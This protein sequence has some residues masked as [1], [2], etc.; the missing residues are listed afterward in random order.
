MNRPNARIIESNIPAAEAITQHTF[1]RRSLT[2]AQMRE[3]EDVTAWMA[4]QE[5]A[6]LVFIQQELAA[7]QHRAARRSMDW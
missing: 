5:E 2:P 6:E 3:A 1:G 7:R 4:E